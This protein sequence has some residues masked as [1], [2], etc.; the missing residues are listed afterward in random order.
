MTYGFNYRGPGV[1]LRKEPPHRAP[2]L[3]T[4]AAKLARAV[5]YAATLSP[6]LWAVTGPSLHFWG[7]R[8]LPP[9]PEGW[10]SRSVDVVGYAESNSEASPGHSFT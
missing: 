7:A 4:R 6:A 8:R 9:A 5:L 10:G 2:F 1:S 3:L